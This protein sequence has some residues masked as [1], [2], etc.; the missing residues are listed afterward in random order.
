MR[1]FYR[2]DSYPIVPISTILVKLRPVN[3][4]T[5]MNIAAKQSNVPQ[6]LIIQVAPPVLFARFLYRYL[7]QQYFPCPAVAVADDTNFFSKT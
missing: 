4:Q 6:S 7:Y 2:A 5:R 1:T 3:A